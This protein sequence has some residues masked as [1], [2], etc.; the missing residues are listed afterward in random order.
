[1]NRNRHIELAWRE[2]CLASRGQPVA[3]AFSPLT[4]AVRT[5]LHTLRRA[6]ASRVR[7]S[8]LDWQV[9][10][11]ALTSCVYAASALGAI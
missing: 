3:P 9:T 1:M 7:L 10:L 8:R 5:K 6:R 2:Q 4:P 11:L